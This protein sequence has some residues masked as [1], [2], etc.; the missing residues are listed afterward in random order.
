ML[1]ILRAEW[2]KTK[3]TSVRALTF[4]LP[5]LFALLLV[6][7]FA[8]RGKTEAVQLTVFAAFFESWTTLVI[9]FG[10]GLLPGLMVHQEALAGQFQNL[11]STGRPRMSMFWGKL[12]LIAL[13]ASL[14]TFIATVTLLVAFRFTMGIA[15]DWPVFLLAAAWAA[16][17]TFPLLIFHYWI[18]LAWGLGASIGIG[19]IGTLIAGLMA[20]SL[21]DKIWPVVPWAWPVRLTIWTGVYLPDFSS[22]DGVPYTL[23]DH[24][25]WVELNKGLLPFA[26]F[27]IAM[28][29][30][31]MLWFNR[32][33]GRTVQE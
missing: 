24:R 18:S 23:F 28:L 7:Y 6:A 21:G 3:R 9:P 19:S 17:S 30:G 25:V 32:W 16:M 22:R 10:A 20:T 2:L 5:V 8:L 29:I 14:S 27:L 33:E 4:G 26:V 12:F 31:G 13:L 1:P 15:L 11:L